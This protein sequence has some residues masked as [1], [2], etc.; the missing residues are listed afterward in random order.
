[1]KNVNTI[2]NVLTF[3]ISFVVQLLALTGFLYLGFHVMLTQN[4]IH[5]DLL[6]FQGTALDK[7]M[8][9]AI[10]LFVFYNV[11]TFKKR[12]QELN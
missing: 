12:L 8:V 4:E 6:F 10:V 3:A 1:M 5:N 2:V 11:T 7:A 9:G